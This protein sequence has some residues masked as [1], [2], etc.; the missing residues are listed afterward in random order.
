MERHWKRLAR[1]VPVGAVV[2]I[3]AGCGGGGGGPAAPAAGFPVISDLAV[4]AQ[5]QGCSTASG[6]AGTVLAITLSYRDSDG[7]TGTGTLQTTGTFEPSGNSGDQDFKLPSEAT[8]TGTT[9]G[10][11]RAFVCVHFGSQTAITIGVA[12]LDAGGHSSNV[13]SSRVP[14][15]AGAP[16]APRQGRS[17]GAME[18]LRPG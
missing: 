18:R 13:L 14:A 6:L 8:V 12:V 4:S 10:T 2:I 17:G 1:V 9:E 16:E 5:P 15:P 7:D 3:L 11:I